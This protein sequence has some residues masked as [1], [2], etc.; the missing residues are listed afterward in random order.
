MKWLNYWL[1]WLAVRVLAWCG[2]SV[3]VH[4]AVC[5]SRQRVGMLGKCSYWKSLRGEINDYL[6]G[7]ADA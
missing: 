7:G 6:N 4:V 5:V 3:F 1:C 2:D